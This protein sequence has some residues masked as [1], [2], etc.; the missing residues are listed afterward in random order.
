MHLET[1]GDTI[2]PLAERIELEG[3]CVGV[4]EIHG[5]VKK[6]AAD[7]SGKPYYLCT[8]IT[9][10]VFVNSCKLPVICQITLKSNGAINSQVTKNVN[11]L[12]ISRHSIDKIRLYIC[13]DKGKL[14]SVGA[15]GVYC[16]LVFKN[17]YVC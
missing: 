13:D 7:P 15:K 6:P 4:V 12:N 10:D 2:I 3:Y 11:W 5:S 16:T 1:H 14:I 17:K 9:E 8:D